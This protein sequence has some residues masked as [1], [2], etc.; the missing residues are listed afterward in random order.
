MSTLDSTLRQYIN[1]TINMNKNGYTAYPTLI[2]YL[3][4]LS[5][6]SGPKANKHHINTQHRKHTSVLIRNLALIR[7]SLLSLLNTSNTKNKHVQ[8]HSDGLQ[9]TRK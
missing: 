6:N 8:L 7:I 5:M 1:L 2:I 9:N 3:D 4:Y